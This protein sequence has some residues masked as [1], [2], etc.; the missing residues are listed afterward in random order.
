MSYFLFLFMNIFNRYTYFYTRGEY[1][2]YWL[3]IMVVIFGKIFY[4]ES[5][6]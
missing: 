3:I 1:T 6:G 5:V 2:V 4:T